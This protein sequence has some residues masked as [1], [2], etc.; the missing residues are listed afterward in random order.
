MTKFE[1]ERQLK[2]G[3]SGLPKSEQQ[4]VLEYYNEL[5]SDKIDA[6]MREREIIAEFGNPYDVANKLLVD[7]Y[8]EEKGN[9]EADEYVY[10]GADGIDED[11]DEQPHMRV[12]DYDDERERFNKRKRSRN[13]IVIN[14][15]YRSAGGLAT[16][17]CVLLFFILGACFDMWHPAWMI[18]LAIPVV[19][20]LVVAIEKRNFNVFCYPIF[21]TLIYLAVGFY[22]GIWHP[23]WV[24]FITIPIYY[25]LGTYI[26]K[27]TAAKKAEDEDRFDNERS[28]PIPEREDK[29]GKKKKQR[30]GISRKIAGVLLTIA[31]VA[32]LLVVWA[33]VIAL[34]IAGIGMIGG[35]IVALI[36]ALRSMSLAMTTAMIVLGGSLVA[37]GLGFVMT[38]GMAGVFK[39]CAKMSNGFG[40][41]IS[42][43]F[44]KEA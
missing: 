19:S 10:S 24:L 39:Y 21:I 28:V 5:F 37:L 13:S 4:R 14:K 32:L 42:A 44:G 30:I 22:G 27:G 38:F 18:F 9:R 6:G 15:N 1:W 36:W 31:L 7:F 25:S 41:S 8:K 26:S 20:S 11:F 23:T 17:L 40:K 2:K 12:D 34:F 3:I 35:G 43:C 29:K 16:L 33:T